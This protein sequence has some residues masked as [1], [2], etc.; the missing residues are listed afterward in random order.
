MESNSQEFANH[1][2]HRWQYGT[3]DN[4]VL[5]LLVTANDEVEK[6]KF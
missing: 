6:V 3:C 2:R 1:L 4:T 5:I